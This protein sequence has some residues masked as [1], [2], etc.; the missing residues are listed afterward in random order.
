M[1]RFRY[2][3]ETVLEYKTQTLDNLKTEHALI[4]RDVNQKKEDIKNLKNELYQVG[5]GFD[6]MKSEGALIEDYRLYTMCMN[7][8]E[9][10]IKEE[11]QKLVV[12]K[13]K[14]ERKKEEVVNAKIDTSKFEKLKEKRLKEYHK[15][16]AKADEAFIEEFVVRG[17]SS[18]N[19]LT[20]NARRG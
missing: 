19:G 7:Q 2:N 3:L 9:R 10:Q 5:V 15:M 17:L 16:E 12:L 6:E 14:E 8:I 20:A 11:K 13:K 18:N 1:K 4:L